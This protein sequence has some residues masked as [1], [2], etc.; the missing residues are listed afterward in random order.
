MLLP[1][2]EGKLLPRWRSSIDRLHGLDLST[3]FSILFSKLSKSN[4][5]RNKHFI[6][7]REGGDCIFSPPAA[8]LRN[9]PTDYNNR[10]P[11]KYIF[12]WAET[13]SWLL[14]HFTIH[15]DLETGETKG[16]HEERRNK[17]D[18]FTEALPNFNFA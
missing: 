5:K 9:V 6:C 10:E 11:C 14:I 15:L 3:E 2:G 4:L 1:I 18:N 17:S 8:E 12:L 7:Q 13:Q 16:C